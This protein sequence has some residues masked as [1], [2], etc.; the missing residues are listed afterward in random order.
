VEDAVVIKAL[1]PEF[2]TVPN[3]HDDVVF[4]LPGPPVQLS[5]V[6]GGSWK[7]GRRPRPR[8]PKFFSP[9]IPARVAN[10]RGLWRSDCRRPSCQICAIVQL[11]KS[12]WDAKSMASGL[13]KT[14]KTVANLGCHLAKL[15]GLLAVWDLPTAAKTRKSNT[16]RVR[17]ARSFLMSNVSSI[18]AFG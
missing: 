15:V 8:S 11:G 9:S 6:I 14:S 5:E 18:G 3:D 12:C 13:W 16:A 10:R 2:G 17:A 4:Q 7:K 1:L